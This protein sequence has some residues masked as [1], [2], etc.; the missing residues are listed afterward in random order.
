MLQKLH[1]IL[2]NDKNKKR[3]KLLIEKNGSK[4]QQWKRKEQA[5]VGLILLNEKNTVKQEIFPLLKVIFVSV[6]KIDKTNI[7]N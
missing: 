3:G 6:T 2:L 1:S 5:N 4:I 7:L